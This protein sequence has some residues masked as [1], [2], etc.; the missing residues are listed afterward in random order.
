MKQVDARLHE[1]AAA[2]FP[3]ALPPRQVLLYV[4]EAPVH[5]ESKLRGPDLSFQY[6]LIDIRT[7]NGER[8]LESDGVGDNVIAILVHRWAA[9]HKGLQKGR[10]EGRQEG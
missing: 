5:M 8:L 3:G 9:E 4:G 10:Q 1:V 2:R 7:L 6:R